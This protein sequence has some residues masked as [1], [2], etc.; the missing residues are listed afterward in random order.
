MNV[1]VFGG[2]MQLSHRARNKRAQLRKL[3][4]TNR[5]QLKMQDPYG[6][7]SARPRKG[8]TDAK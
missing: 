4:L 5:P 1:M 3:I 7:L 8:P 2:P 6:I